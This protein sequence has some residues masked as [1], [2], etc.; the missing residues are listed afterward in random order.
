MRIM[1]KMVKVVFSIL[2]G[3]ATGNPAA[4]VESVIIAATGDGI[5]AV[6]DKILARIPP[7]TD[8]ATLL[9]NGE[10]R[11]ANV[12]YEQYDMVREE[13][14]KIIAGSDP[15]T[16]GFDPEKTA[17]EL[18]D[19]YYSGESITELKKGYVVS[20]MV[21]AVRIILL[22]L[23]DDNDFWLAT[24]QKIDNIEGRVTTLEQG[25]ATP[26]ILEDKANEYR[27]NWTD[28][29]FLEDEDSGVTG[30]NLDTLYQDPH[31][32][33]NNPKTPKSDLKEKLES[34]LAAPATAGTNMLVVLGHPGGGKSTLISNILMRCK[35]SRAP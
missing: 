7:E 31:Y 13:V 32:Y 29:L 16:F 8:I 10:L 35:C 14:T 26:S 9:T 22:R 27:D 11:T 28:E 15:N 19:V 17:M 1:E 4:V 21:R 25:Q 18:C 20:A 5:D 33:V 23:K 34:Y 30:V 24:M 2:K 6:R 3:C 12:P